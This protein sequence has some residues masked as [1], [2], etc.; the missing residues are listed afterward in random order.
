MLKK[1]GFP[2]V[3]YGVKAIR[4]CFS[5]KHVKKEMILHRVKCEGQDF[6]SKDDFPWLW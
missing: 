2:E 6:K 3:L 1:K 4:V 5:E